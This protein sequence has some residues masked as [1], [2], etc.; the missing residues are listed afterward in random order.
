M[1]LITF[2]F[3]CCSISFYTKQVLWIIF[4]CNFLTAAWFATFKCRQPFVL[5]GLIFEYQGF[6]LDICQLQFALREVMAV[7][8]DHNYKCADLPERSRYPCLPGTDSR[9]GRSET[10][11]T[12][13]RRRR[14]ERKHQ[15]DSVCLE[16]LVLNQQ[17]VLSYRSLTRM[18]KP[19]M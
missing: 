2:L 15:K 8:C 1:I 3:P 11:M 6:S 12:W 19:K 14:S 4:A 16:T 5:R 18:F 7:W 13:I 10:W 17:Y 9:F